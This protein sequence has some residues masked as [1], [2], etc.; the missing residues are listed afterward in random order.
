M[1]R[2]FP[3]SPAVE[4]QIQGRLLYAGL[5]F[6]LIHAIILSLAPVVRSRGLDLT[7]NFVHW[8][9]VIV[10]AVCFSFLHRQSQKFLPN[11]DPYLLPVFGLL[12]GWGLLTIFRL[13]PSY[14][15]R[16][17]LWL[18]VGSAAITTIIRTPNFLLWLRRYKYIW[19]ICG[20][21]VTALT[22]IVGIYPGGAGP[23]LWLGC[24][25]IYLQPSEPLKLLLI[26]YLAAYLADRVLLKIDFMKLIAPTL[27]L[28]GLALAILFAQRDL[29]TT[30][31][32]LLLYFTMIYLATEDKKVLIFGAIL[33]ISS[34]ILGVLFVDVIKFRVEA[35]LNP[36]L[37]PSGKSY[38]I[39]QSLIAVASG[40]LLGRGIGIGNPVVVPV[41]ISDFVFSAIAEETGLV[42]SLALI[43]LFAT[44]IHR[45]F[46]IASH[47]VNNYHRYLAAGIT[48]FL[49]IQLILIVGGN[50]RML[51]LTGVTLPF[52][53]YGGSSLLT[54]SISIV[55]LLLISNIGE[56]EPAKMVNKQP[57]I[58]VSLLLLSGLAGLSLLSGWWSIVR[59]ENLVNR[60]D[61]PRRAINNLYVKRGWLLDRNNQA[62]ALTTGTPGKYARV[63]TYP[64]LGAT[65]GYLSP[66]YGQAGLEASLDPYLRGLKG[67]TS[68][69][70]WY[71][72][73]IYGSPPPG[74]DIRLSL[75]LEL[76]NEADDL[77]RGHK[78]AAVMLNAASGELLVLASHPYFDP[79]QIDSNWQMWIN[80]VDAPLVN[81]ATQSKYPLGTAQSVFM[82]AAIDNL[83]SLPPLPDQLTAA[84]GNSVF[85][86]ASPFTEEISWGRALVNGCPG[87]VL[88][89][90][91]QFSASE[92]IAL[93]N[94][95]GFTTS[96]SSL[97]LLQADPDIIQLLD[98]PD[99][100]A[101]GI[102]Q[103][104][105]TP[106]QVVI[107]AAAISADGKKPTPV[108]TQAVKTTTQG[109]VIFPRSSSTAIIK[110]DNA[111]ETA[112]FL[113][114]TGKPV[115]EITGL[116]FT[117]SLPVT[118]YIAGTTSDWK[119][120][121]LAVVVLLEEDS[122]DTARLIGDGLMNA[123]LKQAE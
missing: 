53:S 21:I 70:I 82:L 87:P 66:T 5:I 56:V 65:V 37:D 25:G 97:P 123:V 105:V 44:L 75:D 42:G 117:D 19:L 54:C 32:F 57:L 3:S 99:K 52:V 108:I 43:T 11:R 114:I 4:D 104:K 110:T 111:R 1:K 72:N 80:E 49:G 34:G 55:C 86:C 16:Q 121:P 9:G 71:N 89:L 29:G 101:L 98:E 67:N 93:Y 36:W 85:T 8:A 113:S 112:N 74:L 41:A 18:I 13:L 84:V 62:L 91:K 47:A 20:L 78:G 6:I 26:V 109:W 2:L 115:W 118:W 103:I 51:P 107:A 68:S 94:T 35:W 64:S 102:D 61:N 33:I 73:L 40:G 59:S 119:G 92:L 31:V 24:C 116:S 22:F 60:T 15:F 38:Q 77:L 17:A 96:T 88:E 106:L 81:R 50:L 76:Q 79:N 12:T 63:V 27:I 122:P 48:A 46:K 100:A 120:T 39:V 10:W 23:R 45:G 69:S 58:L 14:G 7:I 83:D 28:T 30:T 95:L 90:S